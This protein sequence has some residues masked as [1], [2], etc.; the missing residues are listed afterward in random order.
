MLNSRRCAHSQ[1]AKADN[2]YFAAMR[3]NEQLKG[4]NAVL[5]KVALKQTVA[6]EKLN[7]DGK[8][9]MARFGAL[10]KEVSSYDKANAA[11][12]S[13][14][15]DLTRANA[16]LAN[17]LA[18]SARQLA[19]LQGMLRERNGEVEA[20][21]LARSKA[22]ETA[23]RTSKELERTTSKLNAA[24][25]GTIQSAEVAELK[26]FNED[27]TVRWSLVS[28]SVVVMAVLTQKDGRHRKCSNA[29]R[30]NNASRPTP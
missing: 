5:E 20:Q 28:A 1:K 18:S 19:D 4:E 12:K 14:V 7:E 10:E 11:Y 15:A 13:S 24:K 22:E 16:D 8:S 2:K 26:S 29:T 3:A 27:L 17:R 23:N 9:V 21:T 6:I 25:T 30:A